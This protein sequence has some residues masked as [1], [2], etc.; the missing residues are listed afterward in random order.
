MIEKGW[1]NRIIQAYH[2]WIVDFY[3]YEFIPYRDLILITPQ[4]KWWLLYTDF[5]KWE[6]YIQEYKLELK[7]KY[8]IYSSG[9]LWKIDF[10]SYYYINLCY[11]ITQFFL[12]ER[13]QYLI[14]KLLLYCIRG[15]FVLMFYYIIMWIKKKILKYYK[16]LIILS[17]LIEFFLFLVFFI[18]FYREGQIIK[19]ITHEYC[20]NNI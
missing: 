19:T 1:F 17:F 4:L 5:L 2:F 13:V 8:S 15:L 11:Y 9:K 12:L 10:L 16:P 14:D 20:D 3:E 7:G 18:K 6:V